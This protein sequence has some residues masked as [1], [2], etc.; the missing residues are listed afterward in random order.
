MKLFTSI[1]TLRYEHKAEGHRLTLEVQQS[2]SDYYRSLIPK[3]L[4]VSRPRWQAHVTVVRIGKE[5]PL[6]MEHWGKYRGERVEF[7]YSP[8]IHQGKVYYWLNVFC[9]RLEEI[10]AE[11]GLPAV[12][13]LA[14]PPKGFN[15]FFHMTIAN[16]KVS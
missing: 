7:F 13:K 10:R 6:Y 3:W 2:I 4:N 12:S 14:V 5:T 11:L 16:C 1:G 15:K 9:V 8:E